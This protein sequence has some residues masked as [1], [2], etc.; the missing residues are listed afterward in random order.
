MILVMVFAFFSV[1]ALAGG[2]EEMGQGALSSSFDRASNLIGKQVKDPQGHTVGYVRDL[3]IS[4][5]GRVS[6]LV[7]AHGSVLGFG[8]TLTPI[9]WKTAEATVQRGYITV[10]VDRE[11]LRNAP[12]FAS[13][14]WPNFGA[15]E[16]DSKVHG[17]YGFGEEMT[18]GMIL[19]I[20][21][22]VL[23]EKAQGGKEYAPMEERVGEERTMEEGYLY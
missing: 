11:K 14:E 2:K 10:N 1:Q 20:P 13:G 21:G 18:E 9:P 7:I 5:D 15:A 4:E 19:D 23:E 3:V 6:Y 16:Y 8:G 22:P 12:G 17:Y